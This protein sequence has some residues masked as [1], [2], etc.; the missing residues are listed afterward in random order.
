M[1]GANAFMGAIPRLAPHLLPAGH[2]QVARACNLDKGYLAPLKTPS[3]VVTPTKPGTKLTI[4]P[5]GAV[6]MHWTED[7]DIVKA[8]LA[9]DTLNRIYFTGQGAP[10]AT[11]AGIATSGGTN[12][13][14][15]A[16]ALGVPAPDTG[17]A[18]ALTG[19]A[20]EP[21]DPATQEDR[22]YVVTYVSAWGEE[23]PP[24]PASGIVTWSPGESV[25]LTGIAAV[26][27]GAYNIVA[28]RI[29]RTLEGEFMFV[30]EVDDA[31]TAYT[32]SVAS[33]ALGETLPS[34]TWYPPPATMTGLRMHPGGFVVGFDGKA[35]I[36]S[37]PY[38]PHAFDAN[39]QVIVDAN[40]V[41]IDIFGQNILVTTEDRPYV[42]A[43]MDP[44]TLSVERIDTGEMCLNKRGMAD[45]GDYVVYPAPV[46][47]VAIGLGVNK[48]LTEK[49]YTPDEWLALSPAT[50]LGVCHQGKY[51]GFH[52]TGCIIIDPK[53]EPTVITD[54]TVATAACMLKWCATAVLKI[55]APPRNAPK[56]ETLL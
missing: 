34:V 51:Y 9:G 44:G 36:P 56:K 16:Y 14:M 19:T 43:G 24:S 31:A 45:M 17:P 27:V 3:A 50:M 32:D 6:W 2:A 29:Y 39:K 30:A 1:F 35:L 18:A 23:G 42:V 55:T 10:K 15:A 4:Y 33:S 52:A 46:G 12:Y 28:K 7:V 5:Y 40:I 41:G 53:E 20:T 48:I 26:P 21:V 13:P 54:T 47:L 37:E 22:A 49:M 11:D 8:P 38:L 25:A